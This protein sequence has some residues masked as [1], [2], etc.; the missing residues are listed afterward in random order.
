MTGESNAPPRRN[1]VTRALG[2]WQPAAVVMAAN[3][4]DFF[5]ALGDDS[6]TADD[7]AARCNTQPR[8]TRMLL[9]ACVALD[10]MEREG[11]RYRNSPEARESLVRGNPAFTGDGVA[12]QHDLWHA[13]GR[14]H[15]AVRDNHRVGER[16]SLVEEPEIHRNFIMAMHN[17]A[18]PTAPALVECL[19]LT[20]RRQLFDAGGGPGTYSIFLT[21][22][23]V[24]LR[25]I[26]FDLPQTVEIASEI[27]AEYGAGDSVTTRAGDYFKDDF[28][29]GNDVVLLSAI[30]HSMGPERSRGL[31]VKA[32]DSLDS[33]GIVVVSEGLLD[34]DGTSP[35][36]AVLFSLN[37]LVNTGEG[38]SYSGEEI[39]RLMESAGFVRPEVVDMGAAG[40]LVIGVKP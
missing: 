28:G 26:V 23:Y 8:S 32:H 20:G 29:S 31:L 19:D 15:E 38:Q 35:M 33:G 3:R 7:V 30:L 12:H 9:N 34:E 21:R 4:L 16:Y 17:R 40:S 10:V 39:M 37:M 36:R 6:L 5:T 24:G 11:D 13:W 27:I 18:V 1:P 25:A 2:G 14:L 22:A